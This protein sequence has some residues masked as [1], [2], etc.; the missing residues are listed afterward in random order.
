ML[1]RNAP[2]MEIQTLNDLSEILS[3][4]PESS[5]LEI[6]IGCGNGHFLSEYCRQN[7]HSYCI[8]LEKKLKRCQKAVAK[9][10]KRQLPNAAILRVR[11]ED[12]LQAIPSARVD[13][14]H[15]YFPDPW[16]KSKH[17]KR[18]FLRMLNLELICR[19][20]KPGGTIYFTTDFFDYYLQAKILFCLRR[21]LQLCDDRPPAEFFA[22]LYGVRFMHLGRK[23]HTTA[24]RKI[25]ELKPRCLAYQIVPGH[26]Y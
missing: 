4:V 17:R 13:A 25:E 23:V 1:G 3:S 11:A 12:F 20:L 14:Y 2:V 18:R 24:A 9:V 16:P 15:I 10:K 21:D 5:N 19:S 7:R 6:E 26:E 22:S 8:G